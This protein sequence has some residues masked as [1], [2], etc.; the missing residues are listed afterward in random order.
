MPEETSAGYFIPA[1]RSFYAQIERDAASFY[2]TANIDPYVS[3]FGRLFSALKRA[4]FWNVTNVDTKT[5]RKLVNELLSGEYIREDNEDLIL[6]RDG[7]RL[8]SVVWS[9]GQQEAYPLAL[10]LQNHCSGRLVASSI[11]IEEPEA[12]LFPT[13][14]RVMTE[15]IALA[16]NVRSPGTR[17]FLTTHSPYILTTINNLLQAGM[18][19]NSELS[20][21]RREALQRTVPQDRALAPGSVDVFYMDRDSCRSIMDEETGLIGT[22]E[23]DKASWD[24]SEQFEALLETQPS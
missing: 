21:D 18:L 4:A 8:R 7:R 20:D 22:S 5:A 19:Y 9:S 3:E 13:S 17:V 6:S 15:L 24:L 1:G 12:H 16:F 2:S 23:I 14:Q 10:M 11:F